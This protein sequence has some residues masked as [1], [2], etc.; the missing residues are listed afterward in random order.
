MAWAVI[1]SMY[2]FLIETK[3]IKH[4][5]ALMHSDELSAA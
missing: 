2:E 4:L 1:A 3:K 5:A